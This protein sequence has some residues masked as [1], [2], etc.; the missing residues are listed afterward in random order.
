MKK[1]S[2]LYSTYQKHNGEVFYYSAN[3]LT[4]KAKTQ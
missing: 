4:L 1:T 3:Y 2:P